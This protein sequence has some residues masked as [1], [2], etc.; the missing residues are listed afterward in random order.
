M[1]RLKKSFFHSTW[2]REKHL[3]YY[4]TGNPDCQVEKNEKSEKL[5]NRKL[6]PE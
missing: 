3:L 4:T 2:F 1:S 6:L 5:I